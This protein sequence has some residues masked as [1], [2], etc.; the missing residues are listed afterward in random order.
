MGK[1]ATKHVA[2]CVCGIVIEATEEGLI[3]VEHVVR[4]IV[5]V[6][7]GT[8]SRMVLD[9]SSETGKLLVCLGQGFHTAHLGGSGGAD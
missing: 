3:Q 2:L 7:E 5:H 4:L 8:S 1:E 9:T 6:C